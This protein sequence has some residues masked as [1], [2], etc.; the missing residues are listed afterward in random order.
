MGDT[1]FWQRERS[2]LCRRDADIDDELRKALIEEHSNEQPPSDGE[3]YCKIRKYQQKRDRYSEMRWWARPSGHGTRC[4]DQVS[5][6]PDFKAAFDDLL[7]IPGL[8][9]GMRI[10]TLNRMIS[11]RCDDEVLSYLTHIKDVW[12][13]LLHHNKEAMLIVDQATVKAVELMA[14]KSSK[15]DAQALHGQLLSGQIFSGFSL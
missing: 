11:M 6:H 15:R 8:W 9:G 14:P 4:L 1:E 3:I 5:R 10:S 2:Y 7:D 12:S 13:R